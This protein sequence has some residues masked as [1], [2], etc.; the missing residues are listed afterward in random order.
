[1]KEWVTP[2]WL[3]QPWDQQRTDV[4]LTDVLYDDDD[5]VCGSKPR[6]EEKH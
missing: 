6:E 1:M 3:K 5:D 4:C 2:K